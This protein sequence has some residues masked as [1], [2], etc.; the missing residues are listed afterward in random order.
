MLK[1]TR[2]AITVSRG[3]TL[4]A[5]HVSRVRG[6]G[7]WVRMV[8]GY[9]WCQTL[10]LVCTDGVRLGLYG[11]CQT[12][13]LVLPCCLRNLYGWCQTLFLVL[14]CCLR[15]QKQSLTPHTCSKS[16]AAH[17]LM[18]RR[19]ITTKRIACSARLFVGSTP[20]VVI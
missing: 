9:G 17:L 8:S 10:F 6:Y 15:N 19:S 12:L 1:L 5:I 7:W 16:D 14:P 3:M 4:G 11:W 20:G 2:A 13:F 18:I